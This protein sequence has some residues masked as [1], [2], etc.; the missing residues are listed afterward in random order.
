MSV[1]RP[2]IQDIPFDVAAL[3]RKIE[4]GWRPEYLCF[5]GHEAYVSERPG[6]HT[7]SQWWEAEF[8]IGGIRYPTAEHYMM[9]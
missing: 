2:G 3:L 1:N 6:K 8:E 9:A 4:A 7:L 5:W